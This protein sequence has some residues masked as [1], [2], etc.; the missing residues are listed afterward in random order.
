MSTPLEAYDSAPELT[1]TVFYEPDWYLLAVPAQAHG[2]LLELLTPL[3]IPFKPAARPHLS[4]MKDE[5][6]CR[7]K[8]DWGTVFVGES[9]SFRFG[10]TLFDG[11]GLHFWVDC[12]S[13][14]LCEMREHF[15]LVTLRRDD[16]IWLVNFHFTIGRRKKAVERKPRPQLRLCPQSHIDVETG[17]Q[18]L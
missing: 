13:P 4:I 9:V 18:H 7:N 16:G 2:T 1:G 17:M 15:G 3:G 8:T 14:R 10:P 5:A 6:P 12:Y 11:N